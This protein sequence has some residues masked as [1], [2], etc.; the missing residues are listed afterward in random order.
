MDRCPFQDPLAVGPGHE[1]VAGVLDAFEDL[2]IRPA[3]NA[4]CGEQAD[5]EVRGLLEHLSRPLEPVATE[6]RR[7]RNLIRIEHRLDVVIL[8]ALLAEELRPQE[9]R[10]PDDEVGLGPGR[11]VRAG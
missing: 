11:D 6:V 1:D 4:L 2:A 9:R 5:A 3:P 8:K 10:V 7:V